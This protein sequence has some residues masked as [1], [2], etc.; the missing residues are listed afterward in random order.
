MNITR[1]G[2]LGL[3]GGAAFGLTSGGG[4]SLSAAQAEIPGLQ[5]VAAGRG[6]LFG[7]DSDAGFSETPQVYRN[8]F[9]SQCSLYAPDLGW[10]HISRGPGSYDFS[11][12]TASIEFAVSHGRKLTGAHLLW[13]DQVPAWFR[14]FRDLDGRGRVIERHVVSMCMRFAGSVYAWNVVNEAINPQEG[15]SNG[16]RN[17]AFDA[18]DFLIAFRAARTAD[19]GA[20][21]AYND[22]AMELDTADH[23]KRRLTLLKLLDWL[24]RHDAPIDAVGLQSHLRIDSFNFS[25]RK[26]R[27]F[28]RAIASRG[29]KIIISELDVLDKGAPADFAVRDRQVADIYSRFLNVAL[30]EPAVSALVTWGLSDRY[31]W[32]NPG[33]SRSFA[34]SDGLPTRPLPFDVDFQPKPAFYAILNALSEAPDRRTPPATMSDKTPHR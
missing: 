19:P 11:S 10:K 5:D 32:L 24:Q 2:Y 14:P 15:R 29:L 8:L 34:R 28:L 4:P 21:L 9:L 7:S 20:L 13:H 1:R 27:D 23:E 25:P 33:F 18:K 30:D 31:T 12:E 26:Y 17:S 22:Y 6:L 16:L 3:S